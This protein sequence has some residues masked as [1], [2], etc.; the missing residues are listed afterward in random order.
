MKI[1]IVNTGGTLGMVGHPLRAS[2]SAAELIEGL[3]LPKE[4]EYT[5]SDFELR[6]DSTNWFNR[7]RVKMAE[8]IHSGYHKHD[9]S[10][11]L[12]GTDSLSETAA[13]FCMIFKLSMQK[14]LIVVGAQMTKDEPGSDTPKQIADAIRVAALFAKRQV[15]GVYSLAMGSVYDGSR[16]KKINES[17]FN[18]LSTPGRAIVA[19]AF[20]HIR[21]EPGIRMR[22]PK[23]FVQGL[24]MD[25]MFRLP[26]VTIYPDADTPPWIISQILKGPNGE[27]LAGLI[28]GAKGAGNIPDRLYSDS[29][30]RS[31]IDGIAEA[32]EAGVVVGI[33]SP[34]EDGMI[35][36]ER[37]ALGKKAKEAGAIS[38][39]SLTPAMSTVKLAQAIA[40]YDGDRGMIQEY[41]ST[42]IMGEL[43]PGINV[44]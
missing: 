7:D 19:H 23:V 34:F 31:L 1:N 8:L 38:L 25:T 20:P 2:K 26:I 44:V 43:L 4:I 18:F 13:T 33:L 35:D 14:P 29:Y 28:L 37:Y 9:A 42:D 16:L 40:M 32:V 41:I 10:I 17:G 27:K 24:R 15:V 5:F 12:T 39:E 6:E 11:V 36:L 3:L 21:L 30:Q 22:D